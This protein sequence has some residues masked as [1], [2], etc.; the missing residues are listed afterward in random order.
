MERCRR[1]ASELGAVLIMSGSKEPEGALEGIR[2]TL[3]YDEE[4]RLALGQPGSGFTPLTVSLLGLDRCIDGFNAGIAFAS[5]SPSRVPP[6]I[7]P[8]RLVQ[9][10]SKP[11][12]ASSAGSPLVWNW[13][14]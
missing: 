12:P 9:H 5:S 8:S 3:L 6:H 4:G 13:S 14:S 10:V 2:F 1:L 7:T 11:L